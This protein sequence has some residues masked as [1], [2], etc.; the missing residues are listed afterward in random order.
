M[1]N[2]T[3]EEIGWIAYLASDYRLKNDYVRLNETAKNIIDNIGFKAEQAILE[4]I[5]NER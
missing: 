4:N 3:E 2:F 5:R 1:N